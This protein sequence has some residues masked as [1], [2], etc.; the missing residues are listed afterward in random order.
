MVH[1]ITQEGRKIRFDVI[2]SGRRKT[3]EITIDHTGIVVRVPASKNTKDVYNMVSKK[4][5]WIF[6]K[7]EEY[8]HIASEVAKPTYVEGSRL[9]YLGRMI[10]VRII[11]EGKKDAMR[12]FKGEFVVTLVS[13]EKTEGD[14]IQR[15][16]E[17]WITEQAA[18]HLVAAA[19]RY[20]EMVGVTPR[21]IIVKNLRKRWGSATKDNVINL[22]LNLIKAPEGVIDYVVL[23]EL[24]HLKVR[25]HSHHFWDMV[26]R[27]M[28]SYREKVLWLA[29]NAL[30]LVE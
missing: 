10:P 27:I 23:H 30:E 1:E 19:K 24:C 17:K 4:A 9:P 29:N 3:S 25:N 14:T 26:A 13:T 16:Y 12:L 7:Q 8:S 18:N 5:H 2:R 11:H 28:P 6:N 20:S 15:L 22:N 21:R